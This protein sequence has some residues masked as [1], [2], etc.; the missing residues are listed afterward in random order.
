MQQYPADWPKCPSCGAP[1]MDGHITCGKAACDESGRRRLGAEL[2]VKIREIPMPAHMADRPV[3]RR[4]FPVPY[5]VAWLSPLGARLREGQ[6]EPDHRI[7][8]PDKLA[9][10]LKFSLC[11]L[12]GVPLGKWR[13]LVVGPM[14][15]VNRTTAEPDCHPACAEYAARACPFLA[16]QRTRRNDVRPL[17]SSSSSHPMGHKRNPGVAC[18]FVHT[19]RWLK[20]IP[21]AAGLAPLFRMPVGEPRRLTFFANGERASRLEVMQSLNGGMAIL[22]EAA[23]REGQDA[24]A[25]LAC[26]YAAT[27]ALVERWTDDFMPA[28]SNDDERENSIQM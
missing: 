16:N 11:W 10:C 23:A 26:Y 24:L 18:V 17:P 3:D 8:D 5:F 19:E 28:G 20:R 25:E 12:C 22:Q 9:R 6:G 13:A 4:G 27:V 1:A 15:L 14:C 7:A 2:A 21:Q